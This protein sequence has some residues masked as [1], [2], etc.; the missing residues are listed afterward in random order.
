M[1]PESVSVPVPCLVREPPVPATMPPSLMTPAMVVSA[2][3]PAVRF[4][5]P[6]TTLEPATPAMEP[7]VSLLALMAEMSNVPVEPVMF[8]GEVSAR[9]PS[10]E[11]ATVPLVIVVAPV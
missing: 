8:T 1:A 11:R 7:M 6:R 4:F 10:P 3:P 5:A 9:E 2:E